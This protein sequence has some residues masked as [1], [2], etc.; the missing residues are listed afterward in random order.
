M[1]NISV[2]F[3]SLNTEI[4]QKEMPTFIKSKVRYT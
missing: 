3:L 2:I 1:S 4:D